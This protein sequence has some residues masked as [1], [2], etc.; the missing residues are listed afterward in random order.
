M[1]RATTGGVLKS[2]RSNLMNS[3][4]TL[5]KARDTVLSQRVFNSYAEDPAAAAGLYGK[6]QAAVWT[7]M[8]AAEKFLD[9][10]DPYIHTGV[11]FETADTAAAITE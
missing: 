1:I 8:P 9:I 2:Y 3:F 4:I 11:D 6:L 10:R 7:G 5:N